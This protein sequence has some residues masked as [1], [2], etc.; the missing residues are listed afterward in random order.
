MS[1]KQNSSFTDSRVFQKAWDFIASGFSM[2]ADIEILR[3]IIL[4]NMMITLSCIFLTVLGTMALIQ[5]NI[6]L[7]LVDY[8]FIVILVVLFLIQRRE[9]GPDTASYFGTGI[10]GLFLAFLIAY[11]GVSHSAYVWAF[12]YPL[13]SLFLLGTKKGSLTTLLLLFCAILIFVLGPYVSPLAKYE[14]SLIL[15]FVPAYLTIYLFA[16]IMEM[17]REIV[18]R[19]LKDINHDLEKSNRELEEA[20]KEKEKLIEELKSSFQEIKT[21]RG[22]LPICANCKKVRNDSG[23]WERVEEYIHKR[24]EAQFTHGICPD[25]MKKLYD[26]FAP[27]N[28][29]E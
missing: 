2:D 18:Q 15:R 20:G 26:D 25:C 23:Y 14:N 9:K 11:G 28:D 24:S 8:G 22:I 13:I 27:Q 5:D 3:K 10:G 1:Q 12:T 29:D 16:Y 21:L 4:V 6:I 19:R 7:G 17:L